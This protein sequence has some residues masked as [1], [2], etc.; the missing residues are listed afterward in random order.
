MDGSS[1]NTCTLCGKLRAPASAPTVSSSDSPEDAAPDVCTCKLGHQDAVIN[2]ESV[3]AI[4]S[5]HKARSEA[6]E[7]NEDSG[8]LCSLC[9]KP[10]LG[11]EDSRIA[12]RQ[13]RW[14]FHSRRCVCISEAQTTPP[15]AEVEESNEEEEESSHEEENDHTEAELHL[16]PEEFPIECF[17]P[18]EELDL[19]F[20]GKI[21]RCRDKISGE[22]VA[23]KTLERLSIDQFESMR[24]RFEKA[25]QLHHPCILTLLA[26]GVAAESTPFIVTELVKAR[27]LKH[28]VGNGKP[29]PV[30]PTVSSFSEIARALAYAH[31]QGILHEDITASDILVL[32]EKEPAPR[33]RLAN[34]GLGGVRTALLRTESGSTSITSK[35]I[36]EHT[37][38]SPD[39]ASGEP[40]TAASDIYSFGCVLFEAVTG[41]VP[42]RG[43]NDLEVLMHHA[44][45]PAPTLTDAYPQK[46]FPGRL[47]GIVRRC[48]EKSPSRR[49]QSAEHLADDL[50]GV[51]ETIDEPDS[52][53][54]E[55][56]TSIIHKP[57][58]PKRRKNTW[59]AQLSITLVL[60]LVGL[61]LY[62][63]RISDLIKEIPDEI[64]VM[65]LNMLAT[66]GNLQAKAELGRRY[67]NG[68]GVKKNPTL[69]FELFRSAAAG[70]NTDGQT[71]L[72]VCYL[73]GLGTAQKYEKARELFEKASGEGN[74]VAEKYLGKMIFNGLGGTKNGADG[75][76]W[77]ELAAAH[78][79]LEATNLVGVYRFNSG[80]DESRQEAIELFETAAEGEFVDSL[81]NLGLCYERGVSV[82][83]DLEKAQ[84]LYRRAAQK[85]DPG[86][87]YRLGHL[88]EFDKKDPQQAMSWYTSA[89]NSSLTQAMLALSR[90]YLG[91]SGEPS[92]Q[93]KFW[94]EKAKNAV[95]AEKSE[96]A[97]KDKADKAKSDSAAKVSVS[98]T[99]HNS[100]KKKSYSSRR[101]KAPSAVANKR[102]AEPTA[103][104]T[105]PQTGS[106]VG[107]FKDGLTAPIVTALS[108]ATHGH[109]TMATAMNELRNRIDSPTLTFDAEQNV[110]HK[111]QISAPCTADDC[112][113]VR[114]ISAHEGVSNL[115]ISGGN[116]SG[117]LSIHLGST[118]LH[119]LELISTIDEDS[120]D[121]ILNQKS[122]TSLFLASETELDANHIWALSQLSELK[123]LTLCLPTL[124]SNIAGSLSA[125]EKLSIV[126][127]YSSEGIQH[128]APIISMKGLSNLSITL[129]NLP[130]AE[131]D[132][133]AKLPITPTLRQVATAIRVAS[134][135]DA[136]LEILKRLP[137]SSLIFSGPLSD[138]QLQG[139]TSIKTL[140][141]IILKDSSITK[142]QIEK[143][144]REHPSVELRI[145]SGSAEGS[146]TTGLLDLLLEADSATRTK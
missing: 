38:T 127:L 22:L 57:E 37:Y 132:P 14:L 28:M 36:I 19:G 77:L 80:E 121:D 59:I 30:R 74:P 137:L 18:L 69:A 115:T 62:Y 93:S 70:G 135:G 88:L 10:P 64:G 129:S 56:Q 84:E 47:E 3:V 145:L 108:R 25:A 45:T 61:L 20:R 105:S 134:I 32:D 140:K 7:G 110:H 55:L 109:V 143:F 138:E 42:F 4:D 13:V 104:N 90:Q 112:A 41:T 66:V 50:Q 91:E 81:F 131:E 58:K 141:V 43:S 29:L 49:Y 8:A 122:L 118:K 133:K 136:Q 95:K 40:Y 15:G 52:A 17:R 102:A 11:Q 117:D 130:A 87:Q 107:L 60:S 6:G 23:V 1:Q 26:C 97:P 21:Y 120:I 123:S 85:E 82:N 34:F 101:A 73:E 46:V 86:S 72:G 12:V 76:K 139:L 92:A 106:Q 124:P 44:S 67:L 98:K 113:E 27:S 71:W 63:Y 119:H 79:D 51:L 125:L 89:A 96:P 54:T 146:R 48:L 111:V 94:Y 16:E 53:I 100:S 35:P 103:S 75:M 99:K 78:G 116:I 128:L 39:L 142:E 33:V 9:E 31:Q 114:T 126:E 65:E 2:E 24:E 144:K 5:E 83:R 68:I